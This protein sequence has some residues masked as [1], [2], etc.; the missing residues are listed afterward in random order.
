[1]KSQKKTQQGQMGMGRKFEGLGGHWSKDLSRADLQYIPTL[2]DWFLFTWKLPTVKVA[3]SVRSAFS[4]NNR[5]RGINMF[6][7]F[8]K[9]N[10]K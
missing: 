1:M 3:V 10:T 5:A 2:T 4:P 8:E 9:V 6:K 7:L